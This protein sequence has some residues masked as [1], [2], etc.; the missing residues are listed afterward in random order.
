MGHQS[1]TRTTN[2]FISAMTIAVSF[3]AST[4]LSGCLGFLPP[5]I[6]VTIE[7]RQNVPIS[8]LSAASGSAD[9]SLG[10]VCGLFN[11]DELDAMVRAAAGDL[12]ADLTTITRVEL[13]STE[14]TATEGD[15][16]PFETAVLDLTIEGSGGETLL[17]GTAANNDGLGTAFS[18]RLNSPVDL[19]ND[20]EE[21]ECGSPTLHLDGG[22]F[23][24]ADAI[25]FNVVVK[26]LVYTEVRAI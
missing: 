19:L 8:A 13:R 21:D 14:I 11:D 17:L 16:D 5:P 24:E 10:E 7:L 25:T 26:L 3:V 9:V 15:F 1:N 18:L 23:L 4:Q 6:P 20:L 2:H 22:G 12:I